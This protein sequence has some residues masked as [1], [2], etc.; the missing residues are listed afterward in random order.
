MFAIDTVLNLIFNAVLGEQENPVADNLSIA[1]I[2]FLGILFVPYI[3]T[4]LCQA[5]PIWGLRM[6]IKRPRYNLIPCILI[7]AIIF[8][9]QH[10]YSW[11]YMVGTFI[12]G[13]PMAAL[14]Y[15]CRYRRENAFIVV[16]AY[17]GLWNA[18]GFLLD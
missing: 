7:S 8:G 16:F 2:I 4:F 10:T 11:Q 1:G 14:Y 17:H 6:L 12:F 9:V 15:L 18:F 13:I 3:E 5:L